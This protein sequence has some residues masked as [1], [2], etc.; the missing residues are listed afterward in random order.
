MHPGTVDTGL[1]RHIDPFASASSRALN[2]VKYYL[3]AYVCLFMDMDMGA[4][5]Q[6]CI[7]SA[8]DQYGIVMCVLLLRQVHVAVSPALEGVTGRYFTPIGKDS[9]PSAHAVDIGLQ[10]RLWTVSEA[11]VEPFMRA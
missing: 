2:A 7:A 1:Y 8:F 3:M 11:L 5:T 9:A 6:V 4:K 10:E